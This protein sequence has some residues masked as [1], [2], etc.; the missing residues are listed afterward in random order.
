MPYL[1]RKTDEPDGRK[2]QWVAPA[3][4]PKSY[5]TRAKARRFDTRDAAEAERCPYNE[6]IVFVS[7]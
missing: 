2:A 6:Q 7:D 5:V 1:I 4:S 3:G